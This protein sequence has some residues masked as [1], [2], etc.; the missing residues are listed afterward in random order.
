V[1]DEDAGQLVADGPLD[2][3]R[4]DGGVN[5]AGQPADDPPV[6]DLARM[7]STWS[8]TMLTI[9]Q[10]G[11][12]PAPSSRK[13]LSTSWPVLAVQHLRV[14]L[15]AVQPAVDVLEGGDRGLRAWRP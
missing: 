5:A 7:R 10:V 1:V 9:V 4:C 8:S 12:Q 3:R 14:E 2:E 6:A 13:R 15:H 11:R